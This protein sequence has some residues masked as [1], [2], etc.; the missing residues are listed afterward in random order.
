MSIFVYKF[1]CVCVH[2]VYNM[3]CICVCLCVCMYIYIVCVWGGGG[4]KIQK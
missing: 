3:Y 1:L 2:N 4:Y